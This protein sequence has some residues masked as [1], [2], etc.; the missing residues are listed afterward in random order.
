MDSVKLYSVAGLLIVE[1]VLTP[2]R[3][4]GN[5]KPKVIVWNRRTF[6]WKE[7]AQQFREATCWNLEKE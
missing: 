5:D 6:V 4:N 7:F 1:V 3:Y 2:S